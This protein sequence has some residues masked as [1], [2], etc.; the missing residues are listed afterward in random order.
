MRSSVRLDVV[1]LITRVS[2]VRG[3]VLG[4]RPDAAQRI[5]STEELRVENHRLRQRL[6]A[7]ERDPTSIKK[8]TNTV[9]KPSTSSRDF[10]TDMAHDLF[11]IGRHLQSVS[12]SPYLGTRNTVRCLLWSELIV[13]DRRLPAAYIAHGCM[14]TSSHALAGPIRSLASACPISLRKRLLCALCL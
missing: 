10:A 11:D 2:I 14:V 12:D 13:A 3:E 7:Y 9:H 8:S 6:A 5:I 1:K 4:G